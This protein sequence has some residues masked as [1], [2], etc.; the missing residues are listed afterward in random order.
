VFSGS[1][2]GHK[3]RTYV[4]DLDGGTP[5]P[6]TPEGTSGSLLSPDGNSVIVSDATRKKYVLSLADHQVFAIPGLEPSDRAIQ[7]ST[8]GQSIYVIHGDDLPGK[9]YK[10]DVRSGDKR[11]F[12]EFMPSDLAG[13]SNFGINLTPDGRF[14]VYTFAQ[15]LAD[16]YVVKGLK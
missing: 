1:E 16:L 13:A 10:V 14:Y 15:S 2:P 4:Q 6:M 3:A 8:D 12:K 7:W 11:L 5:V 9:V